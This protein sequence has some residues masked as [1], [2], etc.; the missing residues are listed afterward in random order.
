MS[1]EL[2]IVLVVAALAIGAG[3]AFFFLRRRKSDDLR[4]SFGREYGRTVAETGDRGRAERELEQRRER[5]DQLQIRPLPA[6]EAER[7]ARGWRE[8][9]KRFVDEPEAVVA[10]ADRLIT[11]VMQRR[12]YPV[13]D[14]EQRAADLSVHH[15][16][17]VDNYRS[18]QQLAE[19]SRNGGAST[20]DLRQAMVHYRVLFEDLLES[21]TPT[22]GGDR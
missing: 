16:R 19:R 12:G 2:V 14:F 7:Y 20:E 17:V 9:Q 8:V 18:A 3:A 6:G 13:A 22:E 11:E 1:T 5:V 21:R 15:A 4:R 10:D